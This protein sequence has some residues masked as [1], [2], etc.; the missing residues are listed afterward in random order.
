MRDLKQD[1]S[2]FVGILAFISR[3]NFV[4]SSVEHEKKVL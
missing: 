4:L 2:L 3:W 1:T